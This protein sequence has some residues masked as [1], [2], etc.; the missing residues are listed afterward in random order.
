MTTLTDPAR[1][2]VPA[3]AP[4]QPPAPLERM[5]RQAWDRIVSSI[6]AVLAVALVVLG[7]QRSTVATSDRTTSGIDSHRRTSRFR[8]PTP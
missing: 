1:V 5:G 6:A 7:E 3:K 4:V 2:E 8:L